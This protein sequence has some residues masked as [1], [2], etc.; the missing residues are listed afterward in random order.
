MADDLPVYSPRTANSPGT[1]QQVPEFSSQT[2]KLEDNKGTPWIWL[3]I[4]S[5]AKGEKQLPIF[6]EGD[7]VEGTVEVDFS[8]TDG[9]KA[10]TIAVH[11]GVTTV[12][13]DEFQIL[14]IVKDLWD[15]KT[16]PKPKGKLSWPFS[17]AIPSEVMASD[18]IKGKPSPFKMPPTFSERASTAYIDYKVIITVRRGAFKVNQAFNT[19]FVYVPLIQA[20]P[21]AKLRKL[22]YEEG[23][24]LP[25]PDIDL[26]GWKVLPSFKIAGTLFGSKPVDIECSF[27]IAEPTM[28]AVG[29]P[30]P[31]Y[32]TFSGDDE[33]ALDLLSKPSSPHAHL[34]RERKIGYAALSEGAE[35]TSNTF[36]EPI[37]KAYFWPSGV[38]EKG[39]RMLQGEILIKKGSKPTF[40]FPRF[41]LKYFIQLEAFEASGYAGPSGNANILTQP[42]SVATI[43]APGIVTRSYAPPGYSDMDEGNYAT[44]V[45]LLENG[46][47]RFLHHGGFQ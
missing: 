44:T 17:I 25:G 37:G 33:T 3:N 10:V 34:M 43:N 32:L 4:R 9:A 35:E 8:K 5:R 30:I 40:A 26:H 14:N 12:G 1:S 24:L 13:Q 19:T 6:F 22:A 7:M 11:G 36:R 29:S 20:P 31:L 38:H 39:K 42:I 45:G 18:K 15:A 23:S 2:Y 47:Q 21:P 28:F 16:S 41:A 27:A 46:N